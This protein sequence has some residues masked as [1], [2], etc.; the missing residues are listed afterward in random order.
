MLIPV[1]SVAPGTVDSLATGAVAAGPG[2]AADLRRLLDIMSRPPATAF[3]ETPVPG[4]V[5]AD[6][7]ATARRTTPLA[8]HHEPVAYVALA[9][10]VY[11]AD[12]SG[13][14]A[15]PIAGDEVRRELQ[16]SY[17]PAPA[18]LLLCGSVTGSHRGALLSA[19]ALGYSAWLAAR[20]R[21]LDGRLFPDASALVTAVARADRDD[22]RRH[23]F[24]VALGQPPTEQEVVP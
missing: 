15:G 16:R 17:P 21:G 13:T 7:V 4:A 5:L 19:A 20:Q 22:G 8:G 3:A 24:T 6:I 18:L 2:P 1:A 23:L 10:G 11:R 9:G 14:L 12:G